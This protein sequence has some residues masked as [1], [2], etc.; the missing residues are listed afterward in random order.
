M[1]RFRL[2]HFETI[3]STQIEAKKPT[4]APG[5]VIYAD[6]QTAGYGRRGRAWEGPS[7]NLAFTMI[8]HYQGPDQ[9]SWINYAISLGLYD[10]VQPLLKSSTL[11][12]VK[13]PND[14]LLDGKKLSGMILEVDDDR[15]LIGIGV[16]VAVLP[17]T[18][19]A[20]TCINDHSEQPQTAHSVL[21]R[22]LTAYQGWYEK[23]QA[24][25]FSGLRAQWLAR[26]AYQ[27]QT[28]TAKLANG[29]I[30]TGVFKDIDNQGALVLSTENGQYKITSADIYL[31][32]NE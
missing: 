14:I 15:L 1:S 10:A 25:G 32:E 28:I 17:E 4:Y 29:E 19:Q 31:K 20:V 23:G 26:A 13:W 27:N 16:N 2:H 24:E 6:R 7:G 21:Q 18:D 22:F 8:D 5:D 30:L 12:N 3:D 9:L 11:L